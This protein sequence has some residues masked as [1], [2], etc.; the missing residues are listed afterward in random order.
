LPAADRAWSINAA[1][2]LGGWNNQYRLAVVAH[3]LERPALIFETAPEFCRTWLNQ[4]DN[5]QMKLNARLMGVDRRFLKQRLTELDQQFS[6]A[7]NTDSNDESKDSEKQGSQSVNAES[8]LLSAI[9][10]ALWCGLLVFIA[11]ASFTFGGYAT[12]AWMIYSAAFYLWLCAVLLVLACGGRFNRYAVKSARWVIGILVLALVWLY[13]PLQLPYQHSLYDLFTEI[14]AANIDTPKWF[15]PTETWSATPERTRWL[16]MSEVLFC[17]LF[18]VTLALVDSRKRLKNLMVVFIAIGVVHAVVG[19][20]GKFTGVLF[21][22]AIQVDG[23]F[24]VARGLFVSRNHFA[25]FLVLSM[26]GALAFEWRLLKQHQIGGAGGTLFKQHIAG[27]HL[28]VP[29]SLALIFFACLNS[30]SR[31]AVLSL[32]LSIILAIFISGDYK[33]MAKQRAFVACICVL[34]LA[35]ALYFGQDIVRRLFQSALSVGERQQQ[36]A[37]TWNSI[38][39]NP[40]FGY[41]GGS[42]GTVFQ[43]FRDNADLR[44]VYYA[45]SHNH[46]LHLWV[47]RGLVGLLMWLAIIVIAIKYA[48]KVMLNTNS[49]LVHGT[50]A[51][52]LVVILAAL[53]QSLVDFNLQML[54]IRAY[55]F[56]VLAV[57]FA[58]PHIKHRA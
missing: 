46:Y 20:F 41:G 26:F 29:L 16:L 27:L 5:K 50:V 52:A 14:T 42:Y 6:F 36:W 45:Q 9:E 57:V 37:I 18:V 28:L 24:D 54:N 31:G 35:A 8:K 17:C 44:Q 32:P 34:L 55:F 38:S 13:L 19:L 47:E 48:R 22:D 3:C 21:V 33:H 1:L 49:T 2:K 11:A 53:I 43:V 7:S 56:V 4:L 15:L 51:A 30:Q 10:S 25:A 23:H 12:K 58:A 39:E 40:I